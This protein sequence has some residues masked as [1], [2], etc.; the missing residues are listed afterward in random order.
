MG[1]LKLP[2]ASL[3]AFVTI[4][5]L[6]CVIIYDRVFVKTIRRWTKNPRGIA[7]LQRLG[8]GFVL[9]IVIMVIASVTEKHRLIVAKK[10]DLV[11]SGGQVP[12]TIFILLPQFILMGVADAYAEAA[13]IEFFYDQAPESMKSLGTSYSTTSVGIGNFLSS[14]ILST[15]S[16]ITKENGHKGWIQNNL[17]A[18]RLDRYFAFLAVLSFLNSIVFLLIAKLY[19]YKDEVS[20]SME[21]LKEELEGLKSKSHVELAAHGD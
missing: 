4:T 16:H 19:R 17:N 1:H 21:V 5:M 7:L 8:I 18:S 11:E 15:V 6:V 2:P 20:N 12:L 13:K 10:N 9:H 3:G 14:F